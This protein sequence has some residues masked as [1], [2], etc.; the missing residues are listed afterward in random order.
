MWCRPLERFLHLALAQVGSILADEPRS[1]I[2]ERLV[3]LMEEASSRGAKLVCY[4]EC[5]LS[6]FFPRMLLSEEELDK[7][8]DAEMP[9]VS[10]QS[11]F[12]KS[13]ELGVGFYL[14]YA[15]LD[16]GKMFN[17]SI[18]VDEQGRIIGKYRKSNVPGTSDPI[19]EQ[20]FQ[21]LERRYFL[22]RDTGFKVIDVFGAR[23]GMIICND[24]R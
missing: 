24:R 22:P 10:V 3:V 21:H 20:K 7:Y 9:N 8:F 6:T 14:G 1:R 11:L 13:R 19:P 18:L 16:A 4:P 12:D 15:E 5:A 23:V 17:T 2:V